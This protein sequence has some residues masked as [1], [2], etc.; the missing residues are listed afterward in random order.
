MLIQTR[1]IPP[2][3]HKQARVKAW[4]VGRANIKGYSVTV[5][6]HDTS[7]C[8]HANAALTLAENVTKQFQH[9]AYIKSKNWYV[10]AGSDDDKGY[11]YVPGIYPNISDCS[12]AAFT[13]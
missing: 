13:A 7:G 1:Y 12:I 11:I 8:A 6:F 9:L 5:G 3:N 2:T 4:I 10:G